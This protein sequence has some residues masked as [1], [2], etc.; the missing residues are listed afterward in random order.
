MGCLQGAIGMGMG[1]RVGGW[2]GSNRVIVP[3]RARN[4]CRRPWGCP[5]RLQARE[6]LVREMVLHLR[7]NHI[8]G[9]PR[10][11]GP[12]FSTWNAGARLTV[13]DVD[14]GAVGPGALGARHTVAETCEGRINP[15]GVLRVHA[16]ASPSST[17][18]VKG[19]ARCCSHVVTSTPR[20]EFPSLGRALPS[21]G[22]A[23]DPSSQ[24]QVPQPCGFRC[25]TDA[26]TDRREP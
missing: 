5:P 16:T 13:E 2:V 17:M 25:N 26:A 9:G 14:S 1:G 11:S 8:S 19:V 24:P 3:L 23:L 15:A 4:G 12:R 10:F 6:Q 21:P 18:A 7:I 20:G 22:R